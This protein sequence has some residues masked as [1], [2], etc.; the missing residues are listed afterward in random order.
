[1][2]N[3]LSTKPRY[4]RVPPD[5]KRLLLK[6]LFIDK[7]SIKEV[8]NLLIQAASSMNMNYSTAKTI[9][10]I[11]RRKLKL[12]QGRFKEDSEKVTSA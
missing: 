11:Y 7:L 9:V 1:M 4:T 3:T 12:N 5:Q 6:K 2:K 8:T 10:F